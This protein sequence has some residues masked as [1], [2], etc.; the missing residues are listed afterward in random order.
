MA[1]EA[2][3]KSR[4][5][6]D[7]QVVDGKFELRQ[8]LGGSEERPVFLT[9]LAEP[10]T[11]K[12]A[13]KIVP[14]AGNPATRL[15]TWTQI[16]KLSHPHLLRLIDSG[17]GRPGGAD[18]YVLME[19]AEENL[20]QI[21]PYRALSSDETREML[22]PVLQALSYL[23]SQGWVHGRLKP[24]NILAQEDRVKISSDGLCRSGEPEG[25]QGG[26][27]VYLAPEVARGERISPAADVWSLGVTL[28]EVLTQRPP[29]ITADGPQVPATLPQPFFELVTHCLQNDP[30]R[31][32][33]IPQ[34]TARLEPP[35]AT[36]ATLRRPAARAGSFRRWIVAGVLLLA[37][38][39]GI[40]WLGRPASSKES[41]VTPHESVAKKGAQSPNVA[42]AQTPQ[43]ANSA[44]AAGQRGAN[45]PG[46]VA[47]QSLPDVPASARNTIE[48]KVRVKVRVNVD[49]SGAVTGTR[50][51]S[52]GPSQYFANMAVRAAGQWKFTPPTVQGESVASVWDLRFDFRRTTTD[53]QPTQV[54]P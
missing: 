50:I 43:P 16:A 18:L 51:E 54:S 34:I 3:S 15:Q 27:N 39:V 10:K 1:V 20:S 44:P 24:S 5:R 42:P 32:W 9:N 49:S 17:L 36:P 6:W 31:R 4:S 11:E 28:T 8:F 29:K 52:R 25:L 33:T 48:G 14:A 21:L 13:I 30:A 37:L 53:V 46:A 40:K 35:A 47:G 19:Y 2:T 23:H 22:R 45:T 12:A 38:L 41:G 7:G 26:P